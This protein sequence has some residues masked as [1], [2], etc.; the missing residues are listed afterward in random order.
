LWPILAAL[1]EPAEPLAA[2]ENRQ[3][4]ERWQAGR[5]TR[6]TLPSA[7]PRLRLLWGM[8]NLTGHRPPSLVLWW[9]AQGIMPR[10]PPLGE[11]GGIWGS[12]CSV[13]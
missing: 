10:Y 5:T 8:D 11:P 12:P 4:W 7:R 3:Q 13:S 6:M 1:P 2:E 9:F